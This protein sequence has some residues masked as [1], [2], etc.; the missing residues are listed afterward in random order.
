MGTDP[1]RL[2]SVLARTDLEL[3]AQIAERT[4]H[5]FDRIHDWGLIHADY[6]LGNCHWT[7]VG[8]K[9][10]LGVLDFDDFG[11]GPRPFDLGAVLGNLADFPRSWRTNAAAF[12]VGYRTAH[13][14]SAEAV[15]E[16][17]LMMAARHAS[18]CLWIL[19]H[20]D[21]HH[22]PDHDHIRLRMQQARECLAIPTTDFRT[23]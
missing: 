2:H 8:G 1:H 12:I 19:G 9:R 13:Q 16:L 21:G 17:P 22:D 7:S 10:Q 11:L 15:A 5:A 23:D 14:L 4:R 3:F 6:I 18:M 20:G